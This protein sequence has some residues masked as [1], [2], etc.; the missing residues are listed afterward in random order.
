[1]S[2]IYKIYCLDENIKDYYIG[3]TTNFHKRKISHKTKCNNVNDIGYNMLLYKFIRA[4]GGYNNWTF[5]ILE[6]FESFISK[7]DL[8]K[9]EGQ[10]IKNNNPTLNCIIPSG[11]SRNEY[12]LENNDYFNNKRHNYYH[13][14]KDI[15]NKKRYEKIECEFCK[16]LT[17]KSHLKRHQQSKNCKK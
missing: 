8:H 9:I 5:E 1:M 4:N 14:N 17:T 3:S 6:T 2:V 15:I 12:L 11:L 7:K 10:Y 13:N 16:V